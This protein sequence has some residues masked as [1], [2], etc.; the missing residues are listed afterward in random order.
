MKRA[1]LTVLAATGLV[2]WLSAEGLAGG[3]DPGDA[4]M[5]ELGLTGGPVEPPAYR[6]P[7]PVSAP[8]AETPVSTYAN[9]LEGTS[10]DREPA[11]VL[12]AAGPS[13]PSILPAGLVYPQV[14]GLAGF[15]T[16]ER[17]VPL[18]GAELLTLGP[19]GFTRIMSGSPSPV[20]HWSEACET[21]LSYIRPHVNVQML[22]ALEGAASGED[23]GFEGPGFVP[24]ARL[25]VDNRTKVKST[26]IGSETALFGLRPEKPFVD[27]PNTAVAAGL[28]LGLLPTFLA[29]MGLNVS[30]VVSHA[31]R[32][33]GWTVALIGTGELPVDWSPREKPIQHPVGVPVN[34]LSEP[35]AAEEGYSATISG[36]HPPGE[37]PPNPP[38][39][40]ITPITPTVPEPTSMLLV[41]GGLL[42][43][44]LLNRRKRRR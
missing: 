34:P 43:T 27:E 11:Y 23:G 15:A 10:P 13:A 12:A 31:Q 28:D 22:L 39:T 9:L 37:G 7:A 6:A 35:S 41:V 33:G 44:G 20:H 18:A 36:G 16:D 30:V 21:A 40:P 1:T 3:A 32:T 25:V 5:A 17:A 19:G 14:T 2:L 24:I 26:D 8:A 29:Q 4:F 38:P 42:A